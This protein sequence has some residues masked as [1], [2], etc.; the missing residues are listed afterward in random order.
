MSQIVDTRLGAFRRV[1]LDYDLV[2]GRSDAWLW[3][4]PC[5]EWWQLSVAQWHGQA[6]V[7]HDDC[8][9]HYFE[10][11]EFGK[12][13]LAAIQAKILMGENPTREDAPKAEER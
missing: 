1:L 9:H 11:H 5:G 13:L 3:Q 12:E 6:V 4:C 7:A 8:S 2:Q 10:I